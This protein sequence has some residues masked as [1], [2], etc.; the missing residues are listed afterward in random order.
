M[1]YDKKET[2]LNMVNI[3]ASALQENQTEESTKSPTKMVKKKSTGLNTIKEFQA[4]PI[5]NYMPSEELLEYDVY[6][7]SRENY[8][9][10]ST[11]IKRLQQSPSHKQIM[12][13]P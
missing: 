2:R 4:L 13:T 7:E 9:D 12:L 6:Q 3:I 5:T 1:L 10:N 8:Y 11:R